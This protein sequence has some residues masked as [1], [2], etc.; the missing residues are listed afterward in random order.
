MSI[1]MLK[2]VNWRKEFGTWV[3]LCPHCNEPAYERTYCTFCK[4]L[5]EWS[6]NPATVTTVK[7]NGYTII[8]CTNNDILL[9]K[10]D[11]I[12]SHTHCIRRL[13]EAEL[14]AEIGKIIDGGRDS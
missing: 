1:S 2:K 3:P 6:D 12:F 7:H 4:G 14:R 11:R 5:Y 10:G 8:Q 13:T 9:Y